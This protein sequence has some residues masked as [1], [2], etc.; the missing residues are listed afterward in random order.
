MVKNISKNFGFREL[1]N[2]VRGQSALF[3]LGMIT[4]AAG[5]G[6]TLLFPEIIRRI[7][8]GEQA[9]RI[10]ENPWG[11][12]GILIGLFAL[13]GVCF[14]LRSLA[15]G[16]IGQ[17]VLARIRND[18]YTALLSK[19][20][21]FFDAHPSGDLVSRISSDCALLQDAVSLKLS[22]MIRYS[23]QVIVG[24]AL[25]VL[26][27]PRL[28][29]ALA[30]M[31]PVLV[32]F[33]I[34]LGKKLK[35]LSKRQQQELGAASA[36]AEEV[37]AGMRTVLAF[38][39]RPY[40]EDRYRRSN[41]RVLDVGIAR[42]KLSAF[43]ASFVNFLMNAAIV[44][45]L[46][47]GIA[48]VGENKLSLG[49]LTAFMLYGAI[50]GVSFAFLSG[51]YSE[52]VQSYG[53]G[54]RI[55]EFS[56]S[57]STTESATAANSISPAWDGSVRLQQITFAYPSRPDLPVLKNLSMTLTPGTTTALV[58]P[59]GS[60]KSTVVSLVLGLYPPTS[61]DLLFG[62]QSI[63]SVAIETVREKIA[64]VSQD[65]ILFSASIRENIR[66]GNLGASD[67]E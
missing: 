25:M 43:F 30:V 38:N 28:T 57:A 1:L 27:S 59:S 12:A 62:S 10:T 55:T 44:A 36:I 45:V 17:R 53:A 65:P 31:L 29:I 54:E 23:L 64:V 4:L 49:D 47:Y 18:L 63:N 66:Y 32:L 37:F 33:S 19:P 35:A 14:Y 8:S 13:Q 9:S 3:V 58:G 46:I 26:L 20:I 22:V 24:I 42:T 60:G 5:S 67:Q 7:L 50:V 56:S 41:A 61:G 40:E 51:T 15:F 52:L 6:I 21:S 11:V 16:V 34:Y 39:R 2:L 48:L